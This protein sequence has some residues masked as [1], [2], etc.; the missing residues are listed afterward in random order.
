MACLL[1]GLVEHRTVFSRQVQQVDDGVQLTLEVCGA[2][3]GDGQVVAGT[4]VGEH[5]AIPVV[6]QP[7]SRRYRQDVDPI[8]LGNRRVIVVLH[9]LQEIHAAHQRTGDADH[10]QRAGEQALVDQAV[11][12]FVILDGYWFRHFYSISLKKVDA[13]SCG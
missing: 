9:H 1:Q 8:I 3:P 12:F 13:A 10:Q 6:D 11:F 2:L 5:H 4:I 7:T